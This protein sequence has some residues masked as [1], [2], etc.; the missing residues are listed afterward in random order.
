MCLLFKLCLKSALYLQ[1]TN[2]LYFY[3]G[4]I[5]ILLDRDFY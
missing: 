3:H 2:T 5:L 4:Y 1:N